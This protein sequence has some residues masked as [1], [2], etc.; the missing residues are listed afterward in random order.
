[1]REFIV[2]ITKYFLG[3]RF[4]GFFKVLDN[5]SSMKLSKVKEGRKKK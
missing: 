5:I 1:M 3:E 2:S 4:V